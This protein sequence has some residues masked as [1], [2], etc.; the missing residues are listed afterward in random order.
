MAEQS[1][2]KGLNVLS[3][4]NWLLVECRFQVPHRASDL[5][6]HHTRIMMI[7]I[8]VDALVPGWPSGEGVG[9]KIQWMCLSSWVRTPLL[10][11]WKQLTLTSK[12]WLLGG[13]FNILSVFIQ[14]ILK[15][16]WTQVAV[17]S[18]RLLVH[19]FKIHDTHLIQ[20]LVFS[21]CHCVFSPTIQSPECFIC[22]LLV[23]GV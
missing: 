13:A 18:K 7:M 12:Q 5:S 6:S 14:K 20:Y 19:N 17:V 16:A 4:P 2:S 22:T 1:R 3:G 10:V 11:Q 23:P 9:F 8:R 21:V 15:A